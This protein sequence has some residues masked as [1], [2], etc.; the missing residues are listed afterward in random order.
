ME[1]ND[2]CYLQQTISAADD[3]KKMRWANER[4]VEY[5]DKAA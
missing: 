1:L 4:M 5:T 3:N 2:N